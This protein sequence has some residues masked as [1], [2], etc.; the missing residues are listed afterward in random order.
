MNL[1]G[2]MRDLTLKNML[3]LVTYIAGL[4][5]C[6]I[7]FKTITAFCGKVLSI[8]SPFMIGFALAFIFNIPMK[9]LNKKLKIENEKVKQRVSAILAILF[10]FLVVFVIVLVVLPQVVEN[11]KTLIDNFPEITTQAQEW[12]DIVLARIHAS[13]DLI[14][15]I[16]SFQ[17]TVGKTLLSKMT[18]WVPN[19][20]IGF[21]NFT[22]GIVHLFMGIVLA[23]YMLLSKEKL[24]R[25]VKKLGQAILNEKQLNQVID[26]VHLTGRTFESFLAGQLTESMIIGVLCYIGCVILKI[27][28]ASIA[29]V[30]IGFTNII[31]YFGP[32]I[33]AAISSILILFVSPIKAIIFLVFST[34]LQ[35]FESNLIYPHVV[36]NSVGLSALWVLFAVSFG[37]GLFGIPGM[38]FGLPTFSVIYELLR[39]WTNQR[40]GEKER[41]KEKEALKV[42]KVV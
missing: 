27:P 2:K 30:V 3:I 23:V 31:P 37:G 36:G 11:I 19:I 21:T 17:E 29:A 20:A 16:E 1:K 41:L 22:T 25:Q 24:M 7:Y 10:V 34:L 14:E 35:Q 40:I 12:L 9:F 5:L 38:I 4:I 18:T 32:I 8:L 26:I 42:E 28:Y 39:R 6:L 15:R 33:G 13:S